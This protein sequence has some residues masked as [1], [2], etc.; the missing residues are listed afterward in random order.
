MLSALLRPESRTFGAAYQLALLEFGTLL[1][2]MLE[3]AAPPDAP[4]RR[5]LHMAWPIMRPGR[6]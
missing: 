1:K 5:L 2:R 3:T 6:S 4:T